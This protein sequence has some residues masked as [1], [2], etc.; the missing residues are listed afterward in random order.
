[1]VEVIFCI[2]GGYVI[3]AGV[4]RLYR[5]RLKIGSIDA[6]AA[7]GSSSIPGLFQSPLA[8]RAS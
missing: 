5:G 8:A 3:I 4:V 2:V 1:M 6:I 7:W